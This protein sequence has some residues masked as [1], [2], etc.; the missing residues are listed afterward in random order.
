MSVLTLTHRQTIGSCDVFRD[1]VSPLQYYVVP[2][3]PRI[4]LDDTGRPIFSLVWYRHDIAQ[5]S[6]EERR[7]KLGGGILTVSAELAATEA[8]LAEI[9]ATL[10]R[11][12][13][14]RALRQR[15]GD[16]EQRL[17][18]AI[19]L[20]MVPIKEGTVTIAVLGEGP[21]GSGEFVSNLVGVGRVS[22][23]GRQRASFMAKLTQDGAVLLWEMVE[24]NLAAIRIAY[25][26]TFEHR[27][28][29]VRMVVWCNARKSYEAV[30]EMWQELRDDASFS[31]RTEGNTRRLTYSRTQDIDAGESLGIVS[32]ANQASG[33]VITPE[34]TIDTEHQMELERAGHEMIDKFLAAT[35]LTW[36][37]G[38]GFQADEQPELQTEV[39]DFGDGRKYGHHGISYYNLREWTEEMSANLHHTFT[40][41]TVLEGHLAPNDNLSN[42]LQGHNVEDFRTQ[43]ELRADW[44][45]YLDVEVLCT[46][47]FDEDPIDLV[48][49]HLTYD[50]RGSLGRVHEVKDFA[51]RKDSAP[52]RFLAFLAAPSKK[53]YRYEYEV[54]YRGS[55]RTCRVEGTTDETILVLDA[56]RLGVLRV[57]IEI[58][59]IDWDQIGSAFV[60]L[61]YGA[62]TDRKE[63]EFTLTN[64]KPSH[65]WVEVIAR[66]VDEPYHYEVT[67]VDANNQRITTEPSSSRVKRLIIN[68]P[69]RDSLDVTLVPAGE[70]GEGAL[71]QVVVALRYR[72]EANDYSANKSYILAKK[73]D[74]FVWSV[75]LVDSNL[76][77][78]EYQVTVFYADG[79]TR[80]ER[81][82]ASDQ[83]VLA[84]GDPYG[85]RVQITPY[86]IK[87]PPY[88][89][90]TIH[91]TFDDAQT[92]VRA[93]KTMEI[94]DFETP[95]FWRFRLGNPERHTYRYQLTLFTENGEEVALPEAQDFREVLVLKPPPANS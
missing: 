75:P 86:L 24:R 41:K 74:S 69:L 42:V 13:R 9:R 58:G 53:T 39:A 5:L 7:T 18:D 76:R 88:A 38:A 93:E 35:F 54:F 1:D 81:W 2:H 34:T 3:A 61:W 36:N 30:Q 90:G 56:D 72:D 31:D 71:S 43:V 91:L 25:D 11:Q 82:Q 32:E 84:V 95:L 27:L 55:N 52:G 77:R 68:Q 62:G 92:S 10:A 15:F 19:R 4:A 70:F 8:D 14:L 60:K 63:A 37:P 45:K 50:E 48:K 67:F 87:K 22:M 12:P 73:D 26:L 94:T 20:A 16:S 59:L 89:F 44:Y 85:F 79:V 17:Q 23:L 33:V 49:A 66:D 51:F 83:P 21:E 40:S 65:R 78:Y 6:E 29:A 80:E 46:A 28:A 57:D 47:D 64:D